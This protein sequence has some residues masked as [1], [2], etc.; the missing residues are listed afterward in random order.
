MKR[1]GFRRGLTLIEV[2]VGVMVLAAT[3]I[4]ASAMFP[5]SAL[6]R[7]RSGASSRAAA[8]VQRKAEQVRR[9]PAS[10]LHYNGLRAAGVIDEGGANPY[11]FTVTDGVASELIEGTGTLQLTNPGTD[12]VR[13]EIAVQWRSVH[14]VTQELRAVT[15][16]ANKEVWVDQ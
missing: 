7:D 16:V 10:Q 14:A 6:L 9:L 2:M 5:L 4:A 15:L 13:I 8:L 12:L 3:L 11:S 1:R